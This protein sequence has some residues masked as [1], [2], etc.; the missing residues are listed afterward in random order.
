M[1]S[2][3]FLIAGLLI[4]LLVATSCARK[5][6]ATAQHQ[7]EATSSTNEAPG[8]DTSGSPA[9]I[10]ARVHTQETDLDRIITAG[11]L[12]EVHEKAFAIRDLV[13][14]AAAQA[15]V[16]G[17]RKNELDAHVDKVKELADQLDEAGDSG[18]PAKTKAGFASLRAELR[19][20]EQILGVPSH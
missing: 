20:I 14:A 10:F 5:Q 4:S 7:P 6:E 17:A 1:N 19:S 11:R 8:V 2:R 3:A 9:E 15:S 12:G 13:V 18:D 16:S